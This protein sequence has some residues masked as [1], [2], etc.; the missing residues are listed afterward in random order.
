MV[1]PVM[2]QEG[3]PVGHSST[4]SQP[5]LAIG[6]LLYRSLTSRCVFPPGMDFVHGFAH[7]PYLAWGKR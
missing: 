2:R 5:V 7:R 6:C 1:G 4:A 3:Q